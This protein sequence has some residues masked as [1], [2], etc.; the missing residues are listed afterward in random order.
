[1]RRAYLYAFWR[2][3]QASGGIHPTPLVVPN[4]GRGGKLH[5]QR[6]AL[7][8]GSPAHR[9]RRSEEEEEEEEEGA[10]H[11]VIASALN[12]EGDQISAIVVAEEVVQEEPLGHFGRDQ[13]LPL[14]SRLRL[15][16]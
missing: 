9:E 1:M 11:T 10:G 16:S 3:L 15:E 2:A 6:Q 4:S 14:L 12:V 5:A 8:D 13:A 7:Y